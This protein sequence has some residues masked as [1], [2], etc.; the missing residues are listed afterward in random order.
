MK[1]TTVLLFTLLVLMAVL[2]SAGTKGTWTGWVTDEHCGAKGASADHRAC[3]EKC[4]TQGG[5][6]VF[7]NTGDKKIYSLDKQDMA[8]ENL[9]HEVQV[10]GEADGKAIKVESI[11]A[12]KAGQ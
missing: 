2:A 5:K 7:Y 1:K 3:A 12:P 8:K 11:S 6:L 4:L 9:G 10:T